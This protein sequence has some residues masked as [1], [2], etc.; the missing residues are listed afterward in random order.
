MSKAE[1]VEKEVNK[2][3]MLYPCRE[4]DNMNEVLERID[5]N[6]AKIIELLDKEMGK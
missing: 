2:P 4:H 1:V 6:V 3:T 5:A